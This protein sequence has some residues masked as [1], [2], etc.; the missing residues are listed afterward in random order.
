MQ[1]PRSTDRRTEWSSSSTGLLTTPP[2]P[3]FSLPGLAKSVRPA[4]WP[5]PASKAEAAVGR[6]ERASSAPPS[7]LSLPSSHSV[8]SPSSRRTKPGL[9]GKRRWVGQVWFGGDQLILCYCSA[10]MI[11]RSI[12]RCVFFSY[13]KM[14]KVLIWY[15]YKYSYIVTGVSKGL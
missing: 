11:A 5:A 13:I 15:I 10:C 9:G 6:S 12:R 4:G 2:S 1:A 14:K 7:C 3:E 8:D